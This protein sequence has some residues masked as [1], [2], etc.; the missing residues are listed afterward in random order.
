MKMNGEDLGHAYD[1]VRVANKSDVREL[2]EAQELECVRLRRELKDLRATVTLRRVL[3]LTASAPPAPAEA[4]APPAGAQSKPQDPCGLLECRKRDEAKLIKN[5]I[6]EVRVDS[7]PSLPPGLAARVVFL[8]ARHVD[9]IGDHSRAR[10]FCS[11]A[12]AAMKAAMKSPPCWKARPSRVCPRPAG[13]L[14]AS[15]KR[16]GS[17]PKTPPAA[18]AAGGAGGGAADPPPWRRCCGSLSV[19]HGALSRQATPPALVEQAFRQLAYVI[20][21]C[22]LNSLLLR[23]DVCC[24][25]R[26]MQIRYN[27]SVLEEWL[28]SHNLQAG[29]AVAELEPLIQAA[30]L[31]QPEPS[32]TVSPVIVNSQFKTTGVK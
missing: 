13:K 18:A 2:L 11:N 19:L 28:R 29:G 17:E 16:A 27:L 22:S 31:L 21:A 26:G 12:V 23:K 3:A 15:R 8:C 6:T 5:L 9:L 20:T 25:S 1:A 10:S 4:L 32:E 24:W 30:Q 14:G 7:A